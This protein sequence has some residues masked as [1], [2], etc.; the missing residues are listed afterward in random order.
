MLTLTSQ[1]CTFKSTITITN[2][3]KS[4]FK[5]IFNDL[6]LNKISS[7]F[8]NFFINYQKVKTFQMVNI[9]K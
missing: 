8:T 3:L 4:V 6:D 2:I 9:F 5:A 7:S 1:T